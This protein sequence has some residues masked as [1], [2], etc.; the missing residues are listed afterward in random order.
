M[1]MKNKILTTACLGALLLGAAACS[2]SESYSDLLKEE[3]KATNWYMAGKKICLEIPADSVFETGENAPYY[4]MDE[5]GYLYMQVINPGDTVKAQKGDKVY[6]RYKSMNV[7]DLYKYG[8]ETWSGNADNMEYAPAIF[9][10]DNFSLQDSQKYG[11]GIQVPLKYLG[12]N[13]EVNLMLRS[14][15]GF[16]AN[17]ANCIPYAMNVKYIKA[18]Y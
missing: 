13:S 15:M 8:K 7:K 9:W 4:K 1:I 11:E 14:Y 3:E 17:Q 6:F 16:A 12:Y 2:D 5:D 18:E 10:F